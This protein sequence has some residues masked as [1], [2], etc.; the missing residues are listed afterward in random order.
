MI[1]IN[2]KTIND[3]ITCSGIGLHSGEKASI[4]LIPAPCN[5]GISFKRTDLKEGTHRVTIKYNQNL[6]NIRYIV[7]PS[8]ITINVYQKQSSSCYVEELNQNYEKNEAR[9]AQ[10]I[11]FI[12]FSTVNSSL[13]L[14]P[15]IIS[16]KRD[17]KHDNYSKTRMR[18]AIHAS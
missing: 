6:G 14:I 9:N 1:S 7:D 4:T 8:V 5:S 17:E 3:K 18:K 13:S 2:Q 12:Y 10:Y 11:I 16:I 15:A